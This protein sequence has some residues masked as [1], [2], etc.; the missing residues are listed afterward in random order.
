MSYR[1]PAFECENC[2]KKKAS[3]KMPMTKATKKLIMG[4]V[5]LS[6]VI[7]IGAAT[8][9]ISAHYYHLYNDSTPLWTGLLGLGSMVAI[10][11]IGEAWI[12][13]Q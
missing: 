12:C 11:F 3:P 13:Q 7:A 6:I 8:I 2:K 10:T 4:L 1:E 5:L 9:T